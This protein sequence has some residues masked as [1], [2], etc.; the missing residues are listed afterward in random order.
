MSLTIVIIGA[1]GDLTARKLVPALFAL[2]GKGRLADE[3]RIVGVART[4]MSDEDFRARIADAVREHAAKEWD[5]ARWKD[6]AR[7]LF[8]V[9]ADAARADGLQNLQDWLKKNE[10]SRG[11][12]RLYY[13]AV[14]PDLYG[15]IA[16]RLGEAGM[17]RE[18]GGWKRL[19]IEKPFGHDLASCRSLNQ[20]IRA[21]FRE[22]QIYR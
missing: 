10:G 12:N 1:T 17:N 7:H 20:T 3:A 21:H 14:A 11:G 18:D 19:V 2:F 8:Y 22:D 13:L 5:P 9:S 15:G 6:F 4:P 16:T